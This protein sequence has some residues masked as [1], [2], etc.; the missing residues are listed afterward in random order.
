[1]VIIPSFVL[2]APDFVS[3]I[4]FGDILSLQ[5]SHSVKVGKLA[6]GVGKFQKDA[7]FPAFRG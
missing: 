2:V 7:C 5:F 4:A 3:K 1:M 6:F